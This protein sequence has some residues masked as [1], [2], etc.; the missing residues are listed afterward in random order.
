VITDGRVDAVVSFAVVQHLTT[1][2]FEHVLSVWQRKLKPGGKLILHVQ[3]IGGLWKTEDD[4][5]S[6]RS[7]KGRLK[8]RYGLH[9]FGRTEE[10]YRQAV[11]Q[12]GFDDIK[13]TAVADLVPSA[14]FDDVGSQHLLTARKI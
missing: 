14:D 7:I 9:C 8:F 5:R 13:M 3:L 11:S 4:W 10:T 12:Y 1:D 2:T 6:D